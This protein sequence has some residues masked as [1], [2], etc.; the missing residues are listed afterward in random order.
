MSEK[1]LPENAN[2]NSFTIT[3]IDKLNIR[4]KI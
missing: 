1:S 3:N 4:L 2:I